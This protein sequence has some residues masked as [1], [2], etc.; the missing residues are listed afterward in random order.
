MKTK[1]RRTVIR[2]N[3][4]VRTANIETY[5]SSSKTVTDGGK[6]LNGPSVNSV[7]GAAAGAAPVATEPINL[8]NKLEKFQIEIQVLCI[9]NEGL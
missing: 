3:T 9:K 5:E 6:E 1:P 8:E 2:D 4:S 7:E